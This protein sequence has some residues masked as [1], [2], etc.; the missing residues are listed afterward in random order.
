MKRLAGITVL[1][2][3]TTTTGC[4]LVDKAGT[5]EPAATPHEQLL[6]A[7]PD[8]KTPAFAFDVKGGVTP[9]SGVLDAPHET[10]RVQVVQSE[11]DAGFAMTMYALAV[12]DKAWM[13]IL[14]EPADVPGLPPVPRKWLV[15]DPARVTDPEIAPSGYDGDTDPGYAGL[16]L[17]GAAAVAGTGD[18]HYTGTTDLTASTEA[19]I[20]TD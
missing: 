18:G 2:V 14:F 10:F 20:V 11:P 12:R 3:L 9:I 8:E 19:E 1:L 5:T 6:R 17:K 13:K 15:V 4:G 16:V 7:V